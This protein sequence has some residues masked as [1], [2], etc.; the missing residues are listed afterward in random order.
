VK[1]FVQ[2][3][4]RID[5]ATYRRFDQKYIGFARVHWD[6]GFKAYGKG[7]LS[8]AP[9]R[10]EKN[11]PG[12]SRVAY[13]L[14]TASWTVY[15]T[16]AGAFSRTRIGD[17]GSDEGPVDRTEDPLTRSLGPW[18]PES[19]GEASA[20]LKRAAQVFG[21]CAAGVAGVNPFWLYSKRI[22]GEPV[23]LPEGVR[24][25]VVMLIEMDDYGIDASPAVAGG[26]ASGSGYSRMAFA[27]ACMAE[28]IRNLGYTAVPA[29]ND[30]ALSVPMAV[31]A[32]LG[33]FG[34]NGLLIHPV[35]GQRVRICKV[36][37]DLPLHADRPV[38]FGAKRFCMTCMK[39]AQHCPSKSIPFDREPTWE[40]PYGTPSNNPGVLKWY[41]N[42][43]SCYAWWTANTAD[44]SNCIRVCPY[45]KTPGWHHAVPRFF[46][47]RLPLTN[48]LWI[49]LDTLMG[50]GRQ[51]D[52]E[53]FFR[54]DR[55]LGKKRY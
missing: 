36:F 12:Y 18:R 51:K 34:R 50:Y 5:E 55:W 15:D 4:Y 47:H 14:Q 41:V 6:E 23:E 31:D 40:G 37:T 21:A 11:L 32:G 2:S 26:V 49:L 3:P 19:P 13:A 39:C 43:D 54:R 22:S 16:F 35:F 44:C 33:E 38:S 30:T 20:V 28:F 42:V 8:N 45:T 9:S 25:A 7:I 1:D 27:Q 24:H 10:V 29:G 17:A 52:P 53:A 48:R 46:I